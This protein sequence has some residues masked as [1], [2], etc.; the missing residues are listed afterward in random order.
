MTLPNKGFAAFVQDMVQSWSNYLDVNPNLQSGD[1]ILAMFQGISSQLVFLEFLA[2]TVNNLARAATSTGADLDTWMADFGFTRLPGTAATGQVTF[3][4]LSAAAN[5]IPIQA[6][7]LV[8]TIGGAVQY[9]AVAD[10]TQPTWN[11][12]QNAYVLPAG[13]TSLAATV[14]ALTTGTASNVTAGQLAQIATPV[15]G[16]DQVTNGAPITNGLNPES[17]ASFR[18]RF[19]LYLNSLAKATQAAIVAAIVSA[20][21]GLLYNLLENTAPGGAVGAAL[22]EFTAVIDDGSGN[23]P[24][25]LI[26]LVFNAI[27]AVRGFTIL[28]EVIGPTK[29]TPSIALTI[30]VQNGFVATAV[31]AAV[32]AAVVGAVNSQTVGTPTLFVSFINEAALSV[33]GCQAVQPGSTTINGSATDLSLTAFQV[34]RV[35][36]PNVAVGTY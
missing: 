4:K 9:Q 10:P 35:G 19:V 31:Q 28:P 22:G 13:Q 27:N 11:A 15:P 7:T 33:P 1:V 5:P 14:Q 26:N 12:S 20:Q 34:A 30:R 8:Q 17:D 36:T 23:P 2:Q 16:I 25:S 3:S 6:G 24:Q 32:Q 21:Q 29:V 18:A